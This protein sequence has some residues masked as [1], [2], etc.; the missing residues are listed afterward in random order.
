V[1][2]EPSRNSA[3]ERTAA[4]R[5]FVIM[6]EVRDHKA[7]HARRMVD[8]RLRAFFAALREHVESGVVDLWKRVEAKRD[9]APPNDDPGTRRDP[10]S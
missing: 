4:Q 10:G 9:A 1:L 7:H 5:R 2:P 3:A 8:E 6:A